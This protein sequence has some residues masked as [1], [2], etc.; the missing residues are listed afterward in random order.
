VGSA[1]VRDTEVGVR[2]VVGPPQGFALALPLL[3]RSPPQS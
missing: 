3:G 1:V 2:F